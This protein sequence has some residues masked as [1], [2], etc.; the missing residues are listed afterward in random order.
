MQTQK[1]LVDMHP[2]GGIMNVDVLSFPRMAHRIFE[3]VG[4]DS[5]RVLTETGKNLMLRRIAI[6]LGDRLTVLGRPDEPDRV[7]SQR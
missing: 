1:D 2:A 4:E 3:E 7:R 5:R 6:R